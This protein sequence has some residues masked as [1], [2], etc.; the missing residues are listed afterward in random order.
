MYSKHYF[1][2]F[3]KT[4][5]FTIDEFGNIGR[6]MEDGPFNSNEI[7]RHVD[8]ETIF[9]V[10][11][12]AEKLVNAWEALDVYYIGDNVIHLHG[13]PIT[14][15]CYFICDNQNRNK[16]NA[17]ATHNEIKRHLW[18]VWASVQYLSYNQF[19]AGTS[20][21]QNHSSW[22]EPDGTCDCCYCA[23]ST[24]D[25]GGRCVR[26]SN[27]GCCNCCRAMIGWRVCNDT[28]VKNK[29]Y[30]KGL[31]Y[32]CG[33]GCDDRCCRWRLYNSW[34]PAQKAITDDYNNRYGFSDGNIDNLPYPK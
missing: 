27:G 23:A 26:S 12:N 18:N 21:V 28:I 13:Q 3:D 34:Y 32:H 7:G 20:L 2:F 5:D 25:C 10:R 11:E 6:T 17:P 4:N 14:N 8:T 1:V 33:Y 16:S 15:G 24:G 9:M 30:N 31:N 19:N 29:L 22:C